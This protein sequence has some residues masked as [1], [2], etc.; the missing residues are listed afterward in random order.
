MISTQGELTADNSIRCSSYL[1]YSLLFCFILFT[2][3]L[4]LC[5][6]HKALSQ[7][8]QRK[9]TEQIQ[10][11]PPEVW[12]NRRYN[13]GSHYM[14]MKGGR[15]QGSNNQYLETSSSI[16]T[17]QQPQLLNEN[18]YV[19]KKIILTLLILG[20]NRSHFRVKA[21]SLRHDRIVTGSW[22]LLWA[23]T[24]LSIATH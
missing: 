11:K 17:L 14:K 12:W 23:T 19:R 2:D 18:C 16:K 4:L 8:L 9:L 3:Y 20:E 7:L 1:L 10:F 21:W 15:T 13:A 24:S 6:T 22:P 5:S